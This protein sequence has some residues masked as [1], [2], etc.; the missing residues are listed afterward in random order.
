MQ[1]NYDSYGEFAYVYDELMDETPYEKWRDTIISLIDTYGVS[2]PAGNGEREGCECF[3]PQEEDP[4]DKT[5]ILDS[6]KNLLLDLGCGTGKLDELLYEKGYDIM[7]IDNSEDMLAVACERRCETGSNIMYLCQDMRELDLYS[8]VGTVISVCDSINYILNEDEL[9]TVFRKVNNFLYP[10]GIF[11]FDF[12]T[13]YKYREVIGD[14]TIAENREGVSFIWENSYDEENKINEYDLT[15]FVAL[16]E[17][18]D[19]FRRFKE[20]HYQRGY[21]PDFIAKLVKQ[22]GMEVVLMSDSDSGNE[23]KDTTERVL[24]VCKEIMKANE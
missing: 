20:L 13:E 9:L 19:E 10:G 18:G 17:G 1:T 4:F 21:T 11:I 3:M 16:D 8:T 5:T 6:E 14:R 23:V 22:A 24:V 15:V 7:G 2:E 12:N